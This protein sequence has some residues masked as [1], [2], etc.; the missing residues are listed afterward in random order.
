MTLQAMTEAGGAPS[1][2]SSSDGQ[3]ILIRLPER[4]VTLAELQRIKRR[5]VTLHK[6]AI[7]LGSTEKGDMDWGKEKIA[8]KFVQYVEE[9]VNKTT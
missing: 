1:S 9:H 8:D 3:S 2:L 4:R 6:K 5:F 7:T